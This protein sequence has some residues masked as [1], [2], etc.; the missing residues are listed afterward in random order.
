MLSS[1]LFLLAGLFLLWQSRSQ[2]AGDYANYYYASRLWLEGRFTIEMYDPYS[3]NQAVSGLSPQPVFVNF[4]PAPP[5][6]VLAYLPFAC[7]EE[8]WIS[9]TAFGLLSLLIFALAY[10]RLVR[11]IGMGRQWW[12]IL[13]PFACF[14]PMINNFLQGQSYLL[15]LAF[16][17]EGF[18]QWQKGR[19]VRPA[20]LW[21]VPIAMKL[22]PAI[23]LLFLILEKDFRG[24]FLTVAF[25]VFLSLSPI[26]V[27]SPAI[28]EAYFLD[29]VPRLFRG[30]INDPFSIL[31]QSG[32]TLFFKAF[33]QDQHLNPG[34]AANLPRVAFAGHLAFQAII[35]A[36]SALL[37]QE[38]NVSCFSRFA[39]AILA[40][41][42][43]TGY[44]S[45]YSML[46]LLFPLLALGELPLAGAAWKI[47]GW[48]FISL[49][50]NTPAHL[51]QEWPVGFQFPR[52]YALLALL[53]MLFWVLRPKIR[54][55]PLAVVLLLITGIGLLA[56]PLFPTEG[57]YYLPDGRFGLIH[58]YE[59]N[60]TGLELQHFN[61]QG[62][63]RSV[64]A[65]SDK[66]RFS[67]GLRAEAGQIFWRGQQLTY[68]TGQKR[69]PALL[70]ERYFIYLSDE[71]RGVGFYTLRKRRL[72]WARGNK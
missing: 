16:L 37:M 17:L 29:I 58:D 65:T 47:T 63:Q 19:A 66:I 3:F 24:L 56:T 52:L 6:S 14:F 40:G 22:F 2:P 51:L 72:P 7:I 44:G 10:S 36:S 71:G 18:T 21:A 53:S 45:S 5:L 8:V 49:A 57:D 67:P 41:L 4:T 34:P 32:R 33:V 42:L 61:G 39:L 68:S 13:L 25:S 20:I 46:L 62:F 12:L 11:T 1:G 59:L 9:K 70:N 23:L 50:A 35:L 69:R 31:Y 60:A 28:T 15:M 27:F 43:L 64:F 54:L 55:F 26:L 38:K 30:E 48:A